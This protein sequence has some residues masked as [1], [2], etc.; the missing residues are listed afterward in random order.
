MACN[1][2]LLV[3]IYSAHRGGR[4]R[5]EGGRGGMTTNGR[6]ET[7]LPWR[8]TRMFVSEA[9]LGR[10]PQ[11]AHTP[12]TGN[13]GESL[14]LDTGYSFQR[15]GG[16]RWWRGI[17]FSYHST[18]LLNQGRVEPWPE[19]GF[20][21]NMRWGCHWSSSSNVYYSLALRKGGTL[22]STYQISL[23]TTHYG[24]TEYICR[25]NNSRISHF[26]HP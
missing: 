3:L 23:F 22:A 1:R 24:H 7:W 16:N 2:Q 8:Q 11:K 4:G 19:L 5:G 6:R 26:I 25:F 17:P 21:S 12:S 15:G 13:N 10:R 9:N 14:D 18:F 20:H